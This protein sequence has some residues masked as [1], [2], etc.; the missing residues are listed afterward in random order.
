MKKTLTWF[1]TNDED[2]QKEKEKVRPC[3]PPA[4]ILPKHQHR[5]P[6]KLKYIPS[7]MRPPILWFLNL[8]FSNNKPIYIFHNPYP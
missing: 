3:G 6:P 5:S 1:F 7:Q 8:Y 2:K 4:A